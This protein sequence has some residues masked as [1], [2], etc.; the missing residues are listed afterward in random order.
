MEFEKF[1]TIMNDTTTK[2]NNSN[3]ALVTE[4]VAPDEFTTGQFG[5]YKFAATNKLLLERLPKFKQDIKNQLNDP[6]ATSL[7]FELFQTNASKQLVYAKQLLKHFDEA[8]D[9]YQDPFDF[10]SYVQQLIAETHSKNA[11]A[12]VEKLLNYIERNADQLVVKMDFIAADTSTQAADQA[13]QMKRIIEELHHQTM[14]HAGYVDNLNGTVTEIATGLMWMQCADGQTG[15]DCQGHPMQYAWDVAM[16]LADALNAHGGFAGFED[17]RLPSIDELETLV[18]TKEHPAITN[19]AFPN[20][21][22]GLFWSS[23]LRNDDLNQAWNIY[24][25]TGSVGVND[26]DNAYAVRLVRGGL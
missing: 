16:T 17:W 14:A 25:A 18:R 5:L 23:T 2:L 20:A 6:Y 15:L 26:C 9:R 8:K 10:M 3:S 1:K 12:L 19:E 22:E 4:P 21:Y 7:A 11:G 13:E 24:F